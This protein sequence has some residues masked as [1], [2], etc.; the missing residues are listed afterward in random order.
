MLTLL[1]PVFV[2]SHLFFK[3]IACISLSSR[4]ISGLIATP[5]L[6]AS[7]FR[8]LRTFETSQ[9]RTCF[10]RIGL[11]FFLSSENLPSPLLIAFEH[12]GGDHGE[13]I[14]RLQSPLQFSHALGFSFSPNIMTLYFRSLSTSDIKG[15]LALSGSLARLDAEAVG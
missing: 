1:I 15:S 11:G 10:T 5:G 3:R 12:Q 4:V 6:S 9:V 13:V 7:F 8:L 2:S 14:L